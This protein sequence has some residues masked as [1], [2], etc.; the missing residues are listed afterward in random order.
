MSPFW[1]GN[2]S[3][4]RLLHFG[5]I[6]A[7]KTYFNPTAGALAAW[8]RKD[9]PMNPTTSEEAALR[10]ALAQAVLAKADAEAKALAAAA[11]LRDAKFRAEEADN[12]EDAAYSALID[13]LVRS[14]S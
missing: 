8:L 10:A 3:E 14:G 2:G 4:G 5:S 6:R 13:H 11:A 12:R 1:P 9:Q 7:G